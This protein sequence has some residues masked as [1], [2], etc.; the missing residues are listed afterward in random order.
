MKNKTAALLLCGSLALCGC[1][2]SEEPEE[3]KSSTSISVEQTEPAPEEEKDNGLGFDVEEQVILDANGVTITADGL[4]INEHTGDYKLGLNVDNTT[5]QMLTISLRSA[6]VSLPAGPGSYSY[7]NGF[8]V[9]STCLIDIPAQGSAEDACF[10]EKAVLDEAGITQISSIELGFTVHDADYNDI[11]D[12]SQSICTV[13]TTLE[14]DGDTRPADDMQV[15]Y[16]QNGFQILARFVPGETDEDKGHITSIIRNNTGAGA[17]IRIR[18]VTVDG[19]PLTYAYEPGPDASQYS[20]GGDYYEN[21]GKAV[22]TVTSLGLADEV[23][24]ITDSS[25]IAFSLDIGGAEVGDWTGVQT[26]GPI[27]IPVK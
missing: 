13:K 16:D 23:P 7:I 18:D 25:A 4:E 8:Q 3:E 20:I 1:G 21:A 19:T 24:E 17:Q 6:D 27:Q 14:R 10:L 22:C 9:S 11:L 12:G 15:V 5:D 26:I 2:A